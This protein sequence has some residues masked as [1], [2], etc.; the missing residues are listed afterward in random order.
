MSIRPNTRY[1]LY[2]TN[3]PLVRENEGLAGIEPQFDLAVVAQLPS[4]AAV[5]HKL[6]DELCHQDFGRIGVDEP[7]HRIKRRRDSAAS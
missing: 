7:R 1:V 3:Y 6:S 2:E 5:C 4:R